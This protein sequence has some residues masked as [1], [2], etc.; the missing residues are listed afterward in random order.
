MQPTPPPWPDQPPQS[1]QSPQSPQ[2]PQAPQ[3][4][5]PGGGPARSRLTLTLGIISIV[6]AVLI[7]AL[8]GTL[9]VVLQRGTPSGVSSGELQPGVASAQTATTSSIQ[10]TSTAQGTP[11]PG[12]TGSG[13]AQSTPTPKPTATPAG[14]PSVQIF[15]NHLTG[16]SNSPITVTCP[17]GVALSGGWSSTARNIPVTYSKRSGNGWQ[18]LINTTSVGLIPTT[19]VY[20]VC[21]RHVA[22]ASVTQRQSS[23]TDPPN[24]EIAA[25]ALC[26]SGEIIV[27]GGFEIPISSVSIVGLDPNPGRTDSNYIQIDGINTTST[28]Q[29]F[30]AY[31]EC[32]HA[33]GAKGA[34]IDPGVKTSIGPGA[35]AGLQGACPNGGLIAGGILGAGGRPASIYGYFPSNSSTWQAYVYNPETYTETIG[36]TPLCL[37]FS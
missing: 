31:A 14:P 17:K 21:L 34:L 36:L 11:N 30:T 3:P 13:G 5:T 37:S 33:T 25:E 7:V 2:A 15:S 16:K 32:L 18:V 12:G 26:K 19:T 9:I 10:A 35:S 23:E 6:S 8:I 4:S 27:G 28:P 20:V 1:P 29:S 24:N 22:G